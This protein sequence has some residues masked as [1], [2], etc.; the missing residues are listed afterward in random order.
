M[1][2]SAISARR[3]SALH[4]SM[5]ALNLASPPNTL[6]HP[7]NIAAST[8]QKAKKITILV[9]D[10]LGDPANK[11]FPDLEVFSGSKFVALQNLQILAVFWIVSPHIG[12]VRSF[13]LFAISSNPAPRS[14]MLPMNKTIPP[15][16]T[17][18]IWL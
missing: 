9:K 2:L 15:N 10:F 8:R 12:H 7:P 6:D 14:A 11:N 4:A 13:L 18:P 17:Q 5:L 16:I 3:Y 1:G